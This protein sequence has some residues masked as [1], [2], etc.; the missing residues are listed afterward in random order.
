MKIWTCGSSPRS[1][2]R[3]ALTR[4]KNYNR[5]SRLNNI[6]K[7]FRPAQPNYFLLRLVNMDKTWLYHYD[8]EKEQQ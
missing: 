1:G 4:I 2:S 5:T 6:R 3:N 8:P 7:F